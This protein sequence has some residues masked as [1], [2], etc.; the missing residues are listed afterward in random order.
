MARATKQEKR[1]KQ[2]ADLF[3]LVIEAAE[4]LP[5]IEEATSYGTRA[6]RVRG[7]FL[8]RLREDGESLVVRV[9][10]VERDHLLQ[11]DPKVF[12]ITDHYRDYPAVLVH[13]SAVKAK[14]LRE[15]IEQ[16]WRR[17]APKKLVAAHD[18]AKDG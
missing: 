17:I 18:A 9:L 8:A 14:V 10:M 16:G 7:K 12:Y 15:L 6:L 13:L 2:P 11:S 4:G 1:K 3:G 5:G